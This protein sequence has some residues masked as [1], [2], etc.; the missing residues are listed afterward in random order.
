MRWTYH[1]PRQIGHDSQGAHASFLDYTRP[2]RDN[3]ERA[4]NVIM[5]DKEKLLSFDSKLKR[6]FA[7]SV[8]REG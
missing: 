6:L 7:H 8:L 5:K 1:T 4:Y 3:A 2:T